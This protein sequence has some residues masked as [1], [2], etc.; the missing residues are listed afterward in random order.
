MEVLSTYFSKMNMH[1]L[2][3]TIIRKKKTREL[4]HESGLFRKQNKT[5]CDF[6]LRKNTKLGA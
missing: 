1:V 3:I 4:I 5:G 6:F 2:A